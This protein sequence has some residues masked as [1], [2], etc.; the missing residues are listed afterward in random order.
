[1][2]STSSSSSSIL[3]YNILQQFYIVLAILLTCNIPYAITTS[4]NELKSA[5]E[6]FENDVF[7]SIL[8][9][10]NVD[11]L[12]T[13]A[14]G[15]IGSTNLIFQPASIDFNQNAIGEP[16]S[17]VITVF[18]RHRNQ[19][20][21]LGSISGN[22]QDIYTSYF[23]DKVIPPEG[24]ATFNIVFLP[25]KLGSALGLLMIHTSFGLIK[26]D[27]KGE[28]V[29]CPYR[30]TPLINLKAPLNATI[31]PEILMYNYHSKPLQIVEVYSSGGAFQLELPSGKQEGPQAL[32]EIPPFSTKSVIR[33][34]FNGKTPGNHTAYVRIKI[35]ATNDPSLSNRMLVVPIEVEIFSHTGVYSNTPF[36]DFGFL[37]AA[38]GLNRS[39]IERR[40]IS[41]FN[42][43]KDE[44][45]D[46]KSWRIESKESPEV[47]ECM[48]L[49]INK[50]RIALEFD[51]TK[52][53]QNERFNGEIVLQTSSRSSDEYRI[54]FTGRIVK[55]NLLYDV[56][57]LQFLLNTDNFLAQM[58]D[59]DEQT[60]DS[61]SNFLFE[62]SIMQQ[63][64]RTF[65][66][67]NN[68]SSPLNVINLTTIDSSNHGDNRKNQPVVDQHLKIIGFKPT[69][70]IQPNETVNLFRL[71]LINI[72]SLLTS[73]PSTNNNR[74][75]ITFQLQLHTNISVYELPIHIFNGRLQRL[76]PLEVTNYDGTNANDDQF[77]NFGILPVTQPHRGLIAFV[78]PNPVPVQVTNFR[79]KSP[80]G[81]YMSV[82]LRGCGPHQL[83]KLYLCNKIEPGDWIV[84][85]IAVKSQAVGNYSGKFVVTTEV[86]GTFMEEII[87]PVL[88]TTAMGRLELDKDL[89][90]FTECYPGKLCS[91]NL[92][93]YST[94]IK[95]M[96]VE[97]IQPETAG[98][99]YVFASD[100]AFPEILPNVVTDIGRLYFNP[101]ELCKN[102]CY[103]S[104]EILSNATAA[105]WM[106]TLNNF[107]E[108]RKL[109]LD[110]L[111]YRQSLYLKAKKM[112]KTISFKLTTNT[113]KR[114]EFNASVN[115]IWPKFLPN[116]INFPTLQIDQEAVKFITIANPTDHLL[117]VHY[118][119]HDV[120][121]H[122]SKIY[123]PTF[124]SKDCSNCTLSNGEN[125]FS[126]LNE[127][128]EVFIQD[129]PPN[130]YAKIG[131]R[132][133]SNEPGT[134]STVLY[135]RNNLTV[136][137]SVW[138]TARAVQPLF[139]FGNRKSGSQTPLIF[140]V[141]DNHLK[142]CDKP[143]TNYSPFVTIKRT[144]TAKNYG[145]V[146]ITVY[147][148]R[149]ENN[150]CEGFGFKILNCHPFEL[151]PNA[152]EKIE[153]EFSPDFTLARLTRTLF[154]HT[155]MN[156]LV[157]FT[158][159]GTVPPYALEK[160][161]KAIIRPTWESNYR[162]I[163]AGILTIAFFLVI[164]TAFLD[165]DK[166]LRDH[167]QNISRDR[168]PVQPPLDLRQ[169]AV[170]M[171]QE[172][173]QQQQQQ[174]GFNHSNLNNNS[175][176][177][178]KTHQKDSHQVTRRKNAKSSSNSMKMNNG[179]ENGHHENNK[180]GRYA[181]NNNN[182]NSS[183]KPVNHENSS[184]SNNS[185]N[186]N[187]KRNN[188]Q[189]REKQQQQHQRRLQS[190]KNEVVVEAEETSSTTTESSFNSDDSDSRS[191]NT[192]SSPKSESP[193]TIQPSTVEF[194]QNQSTSNGNGKSSK[195]NSK[196]NNVKKSKSLPLT[197]F[198][199]NEISGQKECQIES[200]NY[201]KD[202]PIEQINFNGKFNSSH[203]PDDVCH[204]NG[205]IE[206][207]TPENNM[208][209]FNTQKLPGKTPGRERKSGGHQ[210]IKN[211]TNMKQL[212]FKN[213][214]TGFKFDSNEVCQKN[215]H[216]SFLPQATA[217]IWTE[218]RATFSDVVAQQPL[219]GTQNV[220]EPALKPNKM[221]KNPY[222]EQQKANRR[223]AG[224][225]PMNSSQNMGNLGLGGGN[226]FNNN[227]N[228]NNTKRNLMFGG[229]VKDDLSLFR[230]MEEP[231]S[232]IS[233][234]FDG[235]GPIGT[236][237]LS[238]NSPPFMQQ[239]NWDS[240]N[241]QM[242]VPNTIQ[243]PTASMSNYPT[244]TRSRFLD[245]FP[246]RQQENVN[247]SQS[248]DSNILEAANLMSQF[249]VWNA[250]PN[251]LLEMFNRQQQQ[252]QLDAWNR[253]NNAWNPMNYSN[254]PTAST[255]NH[256]NSAGQWPVTVR[257]PPGLSLNR[258]RQQPQNQM[259]QQQQQQQSSHISSR[260]ED[261]ILS[262]NNNN[263]IDSTGSQ[264]AGGGETMRTYDP[265][266]SLSYLWQGSTDLWGA[267]NNNNNK[268]NNKKQE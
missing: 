144:F 247:Y 254:T 236:P 59:D 5:S 220:Q 213:A 2:R 159:L 30:L 44:G 227:N 26:Y 104:F 43:R 242:G 214:T 79:M 94:F 207:I 223:S 16:Q 139:K 217:S 47:V 218:N 138:I 170:S 28:G 113:V 199:D 208:N 129:I 31:S 32:W 11:S 182:N 156:Y 128:T 68:F 267:S 53:R 179:T 21:Y 195:G 100:D 63:V 27:V 164:L 9:A 13:D 248:Q 137:E 119:L 265:F 187:N 190:S 80:D 149:V 123:T 85:E 121:N 25:R 258:D 135:L 10:D 36:L 83:E 234:N 126:F 202:E 230:S 101:K 46:L 61:D 49:E 151:A 221:M 160:C 64:E 102:D 15:N 194:V 154:L 143:Q 229:R 73:L 176:A 60:N 65:E 185:S 110:W 246:T 116:N 118:V 198:N 255:Q 87:T 257:P 108:Y 23:S 17:R 92:S 24:N 140:E 180:T 152:S 4:P 22:V 74:L 132:F 178:Q 191:T 172:S 165:S 252:E 35:S 90:H 158:L 237:L 19:S 105:R 251:I 78:N 206:L 52:I 200:Q 37:G 71:S 163:S 7:S 133:S 219:I 58:R 62:S 109:D 106:S 264:G 189:N 45:V 20:V 215:N 261:T 203:G 245:A 57:S 262:S 210:P 115:L 240:M 38:G 244:Q 250:D 103:T 201:G 89:L 1:M 6:I 211:S 148:L 136:V 125:V 153:I 231:K 120:N 146:P 197:Q 238:R 112:L 86:E 107:N 111:A 167:L 186:R 169:I 18:N 97:L 91:L 81:T 175:S 40:N 77:L 224:D 150:P 266:K 141:T 232:V 127:E 177:S 14:D 205:K 95:K 212:T 171:Q 241:N 239:Q 67:T 253:S 51:W 173:Q 99:S 34:K 56:K 145:E 222:G 256:M 249:P 124:V 184:S 134:Y 174:Q 131:I 54:P 114:H 259:M 117:L 260:A 96:Q 161:N 55:G 193:V 3:S 204:E 33:V 39:T 228:N 76:V 8:N 82:T 29:E 268:N 209:E 192:R 196:K 12:T 69:T 66:L 147:G 233:P 98:I 50:D 225:V 183:K 41:L 263:N 142:A 168:G 48:K 243:Q 130:S 84:F 93:A 162:R 226:M 216:V 72:R 235:F 88:F 155:S 166:V 122:G 75:P 181:T 42:S 157:N 70:I 188:Q